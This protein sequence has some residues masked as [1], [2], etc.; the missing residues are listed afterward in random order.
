MTIAIIN[1][2][3]RMFSDAFED[4]SIQVP[5]KDIERLATL[6]HHSMEQGQRKYHTSAHLFDMAA[7]MNS[8][9]TLAVLFH[10]IVYYQLDGGFPAKAKD[11]LAS[12]VDVRNNQVVLLPLQEGDT[13]VQLCAGL[14]GFQAGDT[15]PLFGGM[16]EFLSAI[17]A[18]RLLQPYL[19]VADLLA[20]A[21]C[22]EATVPFRGPGPAGQPV[23]ERTAERVAAVNQSLQ[24][25][26]DAADIHRMVADA[27]L[28]ANRDVA[29]FSLADPGHFLA[30]TW[31]LIEES[32]APLTAYIYRSEGQAGTARALD[33]AKKMFSGALTPRQFLETLQP[34]LVRSIASA[35]THIAISRAAGLKVL[36][37]AF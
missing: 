19:C 13:C 33:Q 32:N 8:R 37:A 18:T 31:Q 35:C 24:A 5:M 29:S 2:I 25:G 20:I 12:A 11:L 16:N 3:L 22:I 17:V 23:Y 26:L 4:L 9:Q 15:L 36:E 7:G 34:T 6:V 27:V 10:D 28:M 1:R 30:T 21:T 14:F